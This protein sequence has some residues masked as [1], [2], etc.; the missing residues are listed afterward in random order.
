MNS[1]ML[2]VSVCNKNLTVWGPDSD[3]LQTKDHPELKKFVKWAKNTAYT[4][5][6]VNR[7]QQDIS[8]ELSFESENEKAK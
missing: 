2:P 3:Q 4:T 8:K 5:P 1:H 7:L 6:Q